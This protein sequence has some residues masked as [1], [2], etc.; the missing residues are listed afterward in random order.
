M[1]NSLLGDN[2]ALAMRPASNRRAF[3]LNSV[4]RLGVATGERGV[5]SLLCDCARPI[6]FTSGY[7]VAPP[8]AS[9][10]ARWT[11]PPAIHA[12]SSAR[13]QSRAP[14]IL[15]PRGIFPAASQRHHVARPMPHNFAASRARSRAGSMW[16]ATASEEGGRDDR[17]GRVSATIALLRLFGLRDFGSRHEGQMQVFRQVQQDAEPFGESQGF[18][19]SFANGFRRR[20]RGERIVWFS[21]QGKSSI[22]LIEDIEAELRA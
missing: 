15:K 10:S 8:G 18:C 19:E 11:H 1:I 14:P 9:H 16:E 3:A 6:P 2:P 13:D 17:R 12:S 7:Y 4:E 21:R 20:N 5:T 22:R